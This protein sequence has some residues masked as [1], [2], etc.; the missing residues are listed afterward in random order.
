MTSTA[1]V[2]GGDAGTSSSV[3]VVASAAARTVPDRHSEG[4]QH[5][6]TARVTVASGAFRRETTGAEE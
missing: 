5:A 4:M 1:T 3:T 2:H 6:E